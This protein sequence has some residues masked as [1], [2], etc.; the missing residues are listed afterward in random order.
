[1]NRDEATTV[2][3]DQ[4][5]DFGELRKYLVGQ[6]YILP[7]GSNLA[8]KRDTIQDVAEEVGDAHVIMGLLMDQLKPTTSSYNTRRLL[9][10]IQNHFEIVWDLL[11]ALNK[12][13]EVSG[14]VDQDDVHRPVWLSE[15]FDRYL[16]QRREGREENEAGNHG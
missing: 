3:E 5:Y 10:V 14:Q 11:L 13:P 8:W 16:K 6:K 12:V 1:M 4:L 2:V 15:S 9:E 7:D